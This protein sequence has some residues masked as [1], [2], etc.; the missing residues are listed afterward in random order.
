M[1]N[2]NAFVAKKVE[3]VYPHLYLLIVT[4]HCESK[5]RAVKKP[6]GKRKE[7][8]FPKAFESM[9]NRGEFVP[10]RARYYNNFYWLK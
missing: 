7:I 9:L 1:P 8:N 10:A 4:C 3:T 2:L 5:S 6:E